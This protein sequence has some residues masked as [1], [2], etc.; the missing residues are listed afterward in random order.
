MTV[1]SHHEKRPVNI[2]LDVSVL[3][4]IERERGQI[5]RSNYINDLLWYALV[6]TDE[7]RESV[8]NF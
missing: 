7:E 4:A 5:P 6:A 1:Y 3:E 8:D 2:T